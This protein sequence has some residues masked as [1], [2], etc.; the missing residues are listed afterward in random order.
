MF[1]VLSGYLIGKLILERKHHSNFF[2]V[3]YIRR[4]LRIIPAYAITIVVVCALIN[5]LP[6]RWTDAPVKFPEW[7]YLTFNQG[8]F[9][10]QTGS[11]G[12]HWLGPT[13]TLAVEEHFYLI[14]PAMIVFT[15]RRWL[16]WIIG[17]LGLLAVVLRAAVFWGG[18]GTPMM[19]LALLPGRAD[20]LAIGILAAL[21]FEMR[22]SRGRASTRRCRGPAALQWS[23]PSPRIS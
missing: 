19:V 1:F 16:P 12:A 9:M 2:A 3:F 11:I 18:L 7:A 5:W 17:A 10:V 21:L 14:I 20:T 8:F 22:K 6:S 13:W 4:T 15:P 23:W